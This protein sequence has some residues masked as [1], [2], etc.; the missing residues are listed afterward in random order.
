MKRILYPFLTI[1]FALSYHTNIA[2]LPDTEIHLAD[3]SKNGDAWVFGTAENITHRVGYDNQPSFCPDGKSLL[4]VQV[5]DSTQSDVIQY[6]F[7]D[8]SVH[9]I[10]NTSESEYSPAYTPDHS[11]IG[12]VRVD[13]DSAQRFYTFDPQI[14]RILLLLK[15]VILSDIIAG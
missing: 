8:K 4:Y 15:A 10:T 9:K 14:P 1:A 12:V 2:Q 6:N 13:Q 3:V 7:K 5:E 11:K